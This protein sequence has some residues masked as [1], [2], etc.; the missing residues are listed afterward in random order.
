MR[1]PNTWLL[2]L[3]LV[4]AGNI[5][6]ADP[7]PRPKDAEPV[8]DPLPNGALLRIGSTRF[9]SAS[10]LQCVTFSPDG[11]SVVAGA[12]DGSIIIW[13]RAT[14]RERSSWRSPA[15]R[16]DHISYSPDG[17]FLATANQQGQL[18]V[19][20][21]AS[22]R[23]V[24]SLGQNRYEP[25]SY[26]WAG[27]KIVSVGNRGG[28][29][30]VVEISSG[31]EEHKW[32]SGLTN[33]AGLACS[34][35]GKHVAVA[36][37]DGKIASWEVATGREATK[38]DKV[39]M[40]LRTRPRGSEIL[41]SPDGQWLI[42]AANQQ[43]VVWDAHTGKI[44]RQIGDRRAALVN[45]MALLPNSRFLAVS[46]RIGNVQIVGLNSGAE[47]RT[48][49]AVNGIYAGLAVSPD[50]ET[51]AAVS[52]GQSVRLWDIDSGK[53]LF[54]DTGHRESIYA[55]TFLRDKENLVSSSR[56][57]L[58]CWDCKTGRLIDRLAHGTVYPEAALSADGE[59]IRFADHMGV[60]A[61]RPGGKEATPRSLLSISAVTN[62]LAI[63]ADGL[64]AAVTTFDN[65]P[66][67]QFSV[68]VYDVEKRAE[69]REIAG[70]TGYPQ[71]FAISRQGRWLA[72]FSADREANLAIWDVATGQRRRALMPEFG[73]RQLVGRMVF[74]PDARLLAVM[75]Y[76]RSYEV[77]ILELA[78]GLTRARLPLEQQSMASSMIFS[79]DGRYFVHGLA[80]GTL[81]IHDIFLGQHTSVAAHR[82]LI[83]SLA[84][85][86]DGS[87]LASGGADT[88]V[89]VWDFAT[90]LRMMPQVATAAA[91]PSAQDLDKCWNELAGGD[92]GAAN[93]AIWTLVQSPNAAVALFREKFKPVKGP[94]KTQIEQW[95]GELGDARFALR[96]KASR[97]LALAGEAVRDPLK[98]ALEK[99]PNAEASRRISV[100]LKALDDGQTSRQLQPLRAIEVL[101][102][103]GR[104]EA[105]Q[106]L[107]DLGKETTDAEVKR[108][109]E[110][111]LAR[112]EKK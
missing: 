17:R 40:L 51:L 88:T 42:A 4:F 28:M 55:I 10:P 29:I 71:L 75:S 2:A 50:G 47:L 54:A 34:P 44:A 5:A 72:V 62:Q 7:V 26:G 109:I 43:I 52:S 12:Q 70:L 24:L 37:E 102:R 22:G 111:T 46:S 79:P 112:W 67:R 36:S 39:S 104:P 64:F 59:T 56:D 83:Q 41:F 68:S 66:N 3:A 30:H 87:R 57:G 106:L 80:D 20:E 77:Q 21:P 95:V 19:W 14:G 84:F 98:A 91:K 58:N 101:E 93:R 63:S 48:F 96:E 6:L 13:D 89:L 45:A 74:S 86:V 18:I 38:F 110:F 9:R 32:S 16:L 85:S 107:A 60:Y 90:L 27:D 97:S 73:Q 94:D 82:G 69:K 100:L 33:S 99:G 31:K 81:H 61:W 23:Q 35:D 25:T 65:G 8:E 53:E 108:E 11:K 78:S 105:R 1:R 103:I 49:G 92:G 15:L 76:V